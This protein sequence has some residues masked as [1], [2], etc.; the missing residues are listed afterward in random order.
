M[1]YIRYWLTLPLL[2][3]CFSGAAQA[4]DYNTQK[5]ANILINMENTPTEAD[6]TTLNR[7][8][9]GIGTTAVEQTLADIMLNFDT[10]ISQKD[11]PTALKVMLNPAASPNEREIARALLRFKGDGDEQVKA[12]LHTITK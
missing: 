12:A 2:A 4:G 6:R 8:S 1:K 10:K 3:L 7:I 9:K 5:M 11:K